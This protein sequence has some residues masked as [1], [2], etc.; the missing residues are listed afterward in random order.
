MWMEWGCLGVNVNWAYPNYDRLAPDHLGNLWLVTCA[1]CALLAAQR[2][3]RALRGLHRRLQENIAEV[4]EE[5]E[6]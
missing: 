6:Q 4:A 5:L 1:N 2:R 3:I